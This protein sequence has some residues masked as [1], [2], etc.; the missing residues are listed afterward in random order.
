MFT[1]EDDVHEMWC[2][3]ERLSNPRVGVGYNS[4]DD[5]LNPAPRENHAWCIG[6]RCMMWRFKN[7]DPDNLDGY[8]GLAGKPFV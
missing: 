4:I 8:C 5:D 2:P 6:S 1:N 3:M 7:E